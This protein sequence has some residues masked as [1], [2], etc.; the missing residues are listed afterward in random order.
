MAFSNLFF[1][2]VASEPAFSVAR[3]GLLP[4]SVLVTPR[5]GATSTCRMDR[6]PGP[7]AWVGPMCLPRACAVQLQHISAPQPRQHC[8]NI[9]FL[10]VKHTISHCCLLLGSKVNSCGNKFNVCLRRDKR[11][12]QKKP[13]TNIILISLWKK[14]LF[15]SK[16]ELLAVYFPIFFFFLFISPHV[17]SQKCFIILHLTIKLKDQ[18]DLDPNMT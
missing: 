6:G 11:Q 5:P 3:I 15:D 14:I 12:Q 13:Q 8:R 17:K 16:W 2:L 4:G 1:P 10:Q 18:S 7:R 9:C